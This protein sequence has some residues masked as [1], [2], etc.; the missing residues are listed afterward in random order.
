MGN[1]WSACTD[2]RYRRLHYDLLYTLRENRDP[3]PYTCVYRFS[4]ANV[5]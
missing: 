5:T 4:D 2:S 1:H 3:V